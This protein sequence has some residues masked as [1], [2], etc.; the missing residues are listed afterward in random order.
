MLLW[1]F[2]GT[3]RQCS[4]THGRGHSRGN[5]GARG[6]QPVALAAWQLAVGPR[7][8]GKWGWRQ[9]N[10]ETQ[11]GGGSELGFDRGR[12][13][14]D[15]ECGCTWGDAILGRWKPGQR[16]SCGRGGSLWAV[17]TQCMVETGDRARLPWA[18]DIR[19]VGRGP[20]TLNGMH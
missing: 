18:L 12:D 2:G 16:R 10:G 20:L 6:P 5:D 19:L 13:K 11:R 14:G 3:L 7:C 8:T 4:L 15:D 1:C 9:W 17:V